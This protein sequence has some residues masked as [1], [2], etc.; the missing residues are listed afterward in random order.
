[1]NALPIN[2]NSSHA[3]EN[4][5]HVCAQLGTCLPIGDRDQCTTGGSLTRRSSGGQ[6]PEASFSSRSITTVSVM[7]TTR[8]P[9]IASPACDT[10]IHDRQSRSGA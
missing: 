5:I 9:L 1:M 8:V 2:P 7:S 4:F 3:F 6:P 10:A